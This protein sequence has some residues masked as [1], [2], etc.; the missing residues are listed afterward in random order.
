M[1]EKLVIEAFILHY[2]TMYIHFMR[3]MG[4]IVRYYLLRVRILARLVK[5]KAK[6]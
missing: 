5:L 4:E 6:N 2:L 3:E 1:K